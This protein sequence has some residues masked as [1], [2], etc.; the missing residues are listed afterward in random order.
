MVE[1]RA[2]ERRAIAE[3]TST[4]LQHM[5]AQGRRVGSVPFGFALHTDGETLVEVASEQTVIAEARELRSGGMS[6]RKVASALA[7]KGYKARNGRTL[8]P[9]QVQRMVEAA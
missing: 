1:Q 3:R 4:A 6:L 2:R 8:D 9:K 7:L 5:R